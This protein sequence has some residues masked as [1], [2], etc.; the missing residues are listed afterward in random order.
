[1]GATT[2]ELKTNL[3]AFVLVQRNMIDALTNSFNKSWVTSATNIELERV[4]QFNFNAM[5]NITNDTDAKTDP[6][7][8]VRD[9]A[10]LTY[11]AQL[12]LMEPL[13]MSIV[14]AI[15]NKEFSALEALVPMG[16]FNVALVALE[17]DRVAI[18]G[19]TNSGADLNLTLAA[20]LHATNCLTAL[21]AACQALANKK[22]DEA[23]L[24]VNSANGHH[25]SFVAGIIAIVNRT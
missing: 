1:M 11:I 13:F 15:N 19:V 6:E 9:A 17:A 22:Y 7:S 14:D 23:I 3:N 18:D 24:A 8:T 16:A 2:T 10:A 25:D 21:E 12:K 4:N 5:A 20:L